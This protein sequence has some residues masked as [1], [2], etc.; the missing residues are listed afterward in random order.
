MENAEKLIGATTEEVLRSI[1]DKNPNISAIFARA[2]LY[3]PQKPSME[4]EINFMLSRQE[5]LGGKTLLKFI[6]KL[7]A[8]WNVSLG[9]MIEFND[10]SKGHIPMLDL[11]PRKSPEAL[12]KVTRR[13]K[14][15]LE[16]SFGGGVILE[17]RKSYQFIG[18][19]PFS[20]VLLRQFLGTALVTSIITPM[21]DEIPNVHEQIVDY[22]YVGYSLMRGT[23]GLRA[24]TRGDKSFIPKVIYVI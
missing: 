12:E 3:I 23:T 2:Y 13:I 19:T 15:I 10:G 16:P 20:D 9:S 5:F 21:P 22:R 24:T 1:V 8:G 14:E 6:K 7:D 11:A 4:D 17:T 18:F